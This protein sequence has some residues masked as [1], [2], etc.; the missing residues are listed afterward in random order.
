[1]WQ[2]FVAGPAQ[3]GLRASIC[4]SNNK[5]WPQVHVNK[6]SIVSYIPYCKLMTLTN[7]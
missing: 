2:Q 1:M 6:P 7:L 5:E 3:P 4:S